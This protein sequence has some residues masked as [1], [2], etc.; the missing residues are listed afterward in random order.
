MLKCIAQFSFFHSFCLFIVSLDV[1]LAELE[2]TRVA[3]AFLK[4]NFKLRNYQELKKYPKSNDQ[5]MYSHKNWRYV[6]MC[7]I[8][9]VTKRVL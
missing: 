6:F 4:R 3:R 9:V 7:N 5:Q 8:I 2:D 1:D